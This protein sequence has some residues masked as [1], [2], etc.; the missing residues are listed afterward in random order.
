MK[1]VVSHT[2]MGR[3]TSKI[4]PVASQE[5]DILF[6]KSNTKWNFHFQIA[7]L[8]PSLGPRPIST[9][10]RTPRPILSDQLGALHS[11]LS[12]PGRCGELIETG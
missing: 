8:I 2:G 10:I 11:C 7:W 9:A 12:D 6:K 1:A 5:V 3:I 4:S